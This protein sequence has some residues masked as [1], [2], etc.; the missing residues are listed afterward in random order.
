MLHNVTAAL[1]SAVSAARLADDMVIDAMFGDGFCEAAY[2]DVGTNIGVQIR[3]LY[4]PQ[5]YPN[6]TVLPLFD[7]LYGAE[8]C[9]VCVLGFEPN[10][11]H[12]PRLD[13]LQSYLTRSLGVRAHIFRAAAS[14]ADSTATFAM[15]KAARALHSFGHRRCV[16]CHRTSARALPLGVGKGD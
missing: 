4:E 6:A 12:A 11:R 16:L 9:R 5:L 15:P 7:R 8:R 13:G 14:D 2:L 10:A 3:K 1:A